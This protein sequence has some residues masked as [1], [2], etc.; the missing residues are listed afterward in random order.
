[1]HLKMG[2]TCGIVYF[3]LTFGVFDPEKFLWLKMDFSFLNKLII[4][5]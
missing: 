1:M 3:M 4:N 5:F 2:A